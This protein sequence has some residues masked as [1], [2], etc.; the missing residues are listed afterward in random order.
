MRCK[1]VTTVRGT[2]WKE[3]VMEWRNKE[4]LLQIRS[5]HTVVGWIRHTVGWLKTEHQWCNFI[6]CQQSDYWKRDTYFWSMW[7]KRDL[8][9]K[10][11]CLMW[12]SC[13]RCCL[14]ELRWM[15]KFGTGLLFSM[16]PP[17]HRSC[18]NLKYFECM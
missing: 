18:V 7:T 4:K 16:Y 9:K 14:P 1:S 17:F 15:Y 10:P 11:I 6:A 5:W 3:N 2:E 13:A 12:P 8:E